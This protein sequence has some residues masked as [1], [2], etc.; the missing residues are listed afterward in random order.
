MV[1]GVSDG[2]IKTWVASVDGL[3]GPLS[4]RANAS[5]RGSLTVLA[6]FSSFSSNKRGFNLADAQLA[7]GNYIAAIE[8][9]NRALEV[10]SHPNSVA[11][12]PETQ[13]RAIAYGNRAQAHCKL[14]DY[15]QALKDSQQAIQCNPNS[16]EAYQ[17]QGDAYTGLGDHEAALISYQTAADHYQQ[18]NQPSEYQE[19]LSK[20]SQL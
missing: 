3:R 13:V 6:V 15:A 4:H 9:S 11:S 1:T 8:W 7:L 14:H 16:A 18:L 19:M 20:I 2:W 5:N 10:A 17:V 12:H